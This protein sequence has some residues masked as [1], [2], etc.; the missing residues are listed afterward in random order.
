MPTV[1][2]ITP[3]FNAAPF[4]AETIESVRR[5]T[6]DDWEH[7]VVDDGSTDGSA[8]LVEA[9]AAEEP[10][11]R[12]IRQTNRGCASTRNAGVREVSTGSKYLLFFDADDLLEPRML[13]TMVAYLD[14]HP[15]VGLAYCHFRLIDKFG[16]EMELS[17]EQAG[18]RPRYVASKFGIKT[19]PDNVPDTPFETLFAMTSIIP[20]VCVFR[21]DVFERTSGWD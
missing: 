13:E 17:L 5:Q 15:S 3:C 8:A 1:S 11:L 20:S 6:R 10:R 9:I 19:I 7:I 4:I 2:V 14:S 21:R 18:W 16:K 12:L